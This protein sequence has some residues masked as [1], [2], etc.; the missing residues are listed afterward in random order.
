MTQPTHS[1][2]EQRFDALIEQL[3]DAQIQVNNGQTVDLSG[4]QSII[5]GVCT[6]LSA[7]EKD[8]A[9]ILKPKFIEMIGALDAL[10][11]SLQGIIEQ[12]KQ[13]GQ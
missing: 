1:E 11:G 5:E 12:E 3:K 2:L 7:A 8:V 13:D 4:F 6:D 9:D 10:A